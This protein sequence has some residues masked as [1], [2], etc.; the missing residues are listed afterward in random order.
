MSTEDKSRELLSK[1][2]LESENRHEAMI[3][4]AMETEL[5]HDAEL[6]EKAREILAESRQQ[7]NRLQENRLERTEQ[8]I[9]V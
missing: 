1:S 2:R 5:S 6:E 9:E 8:E 4:R 7:A 3:N